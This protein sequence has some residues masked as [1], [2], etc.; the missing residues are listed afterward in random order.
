MLTHSVFQARA[1]S[2]LQSNNGRGGQVRLG[3]S[4]FSDQGEC[5]AAE[6]QRE[7]GQ[8]GGEQERDHMPYSSGGKVAIGWWLWFG[9]FW[10][11]TH[12]RWLW[13]GGLGTDGR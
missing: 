4:A 6:H 8:W 11:L 9:G 10:H 13:H 5:P 2:W 1:A 7:G 12:V 3:H